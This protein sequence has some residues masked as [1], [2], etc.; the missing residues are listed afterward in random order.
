MRKI[1][2]NSVLILGSLLLLTGC[3]R[4][5]APEGFGPTDLEQGLIAYDQGEWESAMKYFKTPKI[6]KPFLNA[7]LSFSA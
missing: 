4:R 6:P 5:V 1:V 2:L 7:A 3:F